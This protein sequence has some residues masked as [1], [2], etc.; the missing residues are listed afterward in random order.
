MPK[1]LASSTESIFAETNTFWV[2]VDHSIFPILVVCGKCN[3]NGANLGR[4]TGSSLYNLTTDLLSLIYLSKV[5]LKCQQ[6]SGLSIRDGKRDK[7]PNQVQ[8]G[9]AV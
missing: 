3:F 7:Q 1:G 6:L 8:G 5:K 4:D 9:Y 2:L